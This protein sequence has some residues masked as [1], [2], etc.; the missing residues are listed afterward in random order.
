M[1]DFIYVGIG[2]GN[3]VKIFNSKLTDE[4]MG[5]NMRG[6]TLGGGINFGKYTSLPFWVEYAWESHKYLEAIHRFGLELGF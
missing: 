5:G 6:L 2:H 3:A 4:D 1:L